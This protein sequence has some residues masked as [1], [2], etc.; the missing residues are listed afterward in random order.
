M[1]P[2]LCYTL[3]LYFIIILSSFY[4]IHHIFVIHPFLSAYLSHPPA[5]FT[6]SLSSTPFYQ[7]TCHILLLNSPT[8]CHP[9]L[10]ISILVP[11]TSSCFIHQLFVVHPFL[12]AYLSYPPALLTN[13]LSSTPF[14]QQTCHILLLYSPT[15]CHPPLFFSILVVRMSGRVFVVWIV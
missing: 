11:V 8:L 14:Y 5:L 10:F 13:S 7:H 6:N 9:P 3:L 4:F 15:L 2:H 1:H 12:S